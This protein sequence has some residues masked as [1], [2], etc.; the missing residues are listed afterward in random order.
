MRIEE[1]D[2]KIAESLLGKL[3]LEEKIGMIHGA[4]L[5][6]TK[7]VERLGIP[8]L[9]M[10]DGPM[11]VR[12]EFEKDSWKPAGHG[13]DLVTYLP[14]NSAIAASW[15]RQLA[16][17]SGK[18]LGEEVRGRGKDIILAPGIN[19]KRS[20]L[21][22][23]NFEYMSE[24]PYLTAQQCVP[25]IQGIQENDVAACVKHFAL[26]NQERNRLWVNTEVE[27][28]ALREIYLPAFQAAAQ[29]GETL[30]IMGAYNLIRGSRCCENTY[31][32]DDILRGEWDW[33][34]IVISD[35]GGVLRTK[36]SAEASLDIEMSIYPNFDT[37][38]FATPLLE[39]VQKGE[40]E[41]HWIDEKVYRILCVMSALHMLDGKRKKGC[42]NT[43]EHRQA[44]LETA[45]ESIVLLKNA[46][47]CLPLQEE[48]MDRLLVIG[49][50]AETMH[51][52]GGG[53]AEIKALYEITPLMGIQCALGGN[54]QVTY[55]KGYYVPPIAELEENWQ[56][57][58]FKDG[59]G[60]AEVLDEETAKKR[61]EL[62][63]EAVALAREYEHVIFVGGLDHQYDVEDRD[64]ANMKLPY[65]QDELLEEL[66]AVNPD[67]VVV[68]TAGSPVEMHR[69]A[70]QAKAIVWNW[71]NGMEGGHA[72][73]QVL[74]GKINPSGK[75]PETFPITETDCSAH[76]VGDFGKKEEVQYREGIYVGY[77]YY[78]KKEVPVQ[79]P[80]GH[81]LSYT[82]F[83]Y[84]QME[85]EEDSQKIWVS[86]KIKN[87]GNC[88]GK[89]IV[90]CYVAAP[91]EQIDR[92]KKELKGYEKIYLEPGEEKNVTLQILKEDLRYY[93]ETK[94]QMVWEPGNYEILLGASSAD[95]RLNKKIRLE[96]L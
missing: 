50:N 76:C 72:L 5:F 63:E 70:D 27:E 62:R 75:L 90:Q 69:W 89:E 55:A 6:E 3:T 24:D 14:S 92:P 28:R 30:S 13:D 12:M 44:A 43:P 38:C 57:D 18:V 41:E 37:Y 23:R 74:F 95:I 80:F 25:L 2:Q 68:L 35:W 36:E 51:S 53:S 96:K 31:L 79:F 48:T 19:I 46:E 94:R 59:V 85:I 16:Y 15:N 73:A 54:T 56:L 8:P 49:C 58:S 64:R 17:Q 82:T 93:D 42:Y 86:C 9:K 45:Q 78:E 10:S 34:G 33:K 26:N 32:L 83:A 29:K 11:G 52:C 71:Y 21:C 65:G 1:K 61:K 81:G 88:A 20:P 7:G 66:L 67:M 39:A 4:G 91:G 22:G 87:T 77:R 60:T 84:D 40:I 47:H